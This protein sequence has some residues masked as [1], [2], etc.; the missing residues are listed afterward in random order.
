MLD[1]VAVV[2]EPP[3]L[4][5][6]LYSLSIDIF[7]SHIFLYTIHQQ[8]G[9]PV[10]PGIWGRARGWRLQKAPYSSSYQLGVNPLTMEGSELRRLS[11]GRQHG[12]PL[13]R[14][15]GIGLGYR[16]RQLLVG[17]QPGMPWPMEQGRGLHW[18]R[19]APSSNCFWSC[20]P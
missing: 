14:V 1:G 3:P 13:H 4:W 2:Y 12:R 9:S 20:L 7:V 6:V 10:G 15:Q 5:P 19:K 18:A 8:G 11:A 17:R 16:L